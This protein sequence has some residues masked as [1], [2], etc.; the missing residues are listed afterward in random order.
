LHEPLKELQ[1]PVQPSHLLSDLF[2]LDQNL[3]FGSW[4][5][6]P[7]PRPPTGGT[8][9]TQRQ[10]S[11]SSQPPPSIIKLQPITLAK[12]RLFQLTPVRQPPSPITPTVEEQFHDFNHDDEEQLEYEDIDPMVQVQSPLWRP[13]SVPLDLKEIPE[14]QES[15][16]IERDVTQTLEDIVGR[17]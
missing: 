4:F 11:L 9:P 10:Q 15:E 7:S 3:P 12:S 1:P 17:L 16:D 6:T 14:D 5:R 13:T 2:D 8:A